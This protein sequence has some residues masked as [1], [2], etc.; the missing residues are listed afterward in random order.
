MKGVYIFVALFLFVVTQAATAAN[1]FGNSPS[2]N[3]GVP[4]TA[5]LEV[6]DI[7]P[8]EYNH[9]SRLIS[10]MSGFW[11][12][13]VIEI[14]CKGDIA[15]AVEEKQEYKV[16]ARGKTDYMPVEDT[17]ELRF[18]SRWQGRTRNVTRPENFRLLLTRQ[19]LR[20]DRNIPAGDVVTVK[21]LADFLV[22]HKKSNVRNRS[23]GVVTQEIVRS[24][25]LEHN[26][27]KIEYQSFTNGRLVS[28]SQWELRR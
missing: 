23:G 12:G 16:D 4:L 5:E 10:F 13:S 9:L 2:N 1:C 20:L 14:T 28:K 19:R 26:V 8:A 7:S 17:L 24:F 21:V 18:R 27:L 22:F 3:Q 15:A 6:K 11:S 25:L